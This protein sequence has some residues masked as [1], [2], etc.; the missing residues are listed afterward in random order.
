MRY[1]NIINFSID[2]ITLFHIKVIKN[3]KKNET[4][5]EEVFL[6]YLTLSQL[7]IKYF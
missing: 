4:K 5:L 3:E 1:G 6:E 7:G 2:F